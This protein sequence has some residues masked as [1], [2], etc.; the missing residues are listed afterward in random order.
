M[1]VGAAGVEPATC[2]VRAGCSAQLS[3][4]PFV[5]HGGADG[6]RTRTFSLDRRAALAL[7]YGANC[8]NPPRKKPRGKSGTSGGIR[9]L[10]LAVR[11]RVLWFL[12]SY[13]GIGLAGRIRTCGLV[14]PDHAR[15]PA[16]LQRDE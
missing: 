10:G 6:T 4:A 8:S 12:L 14:V 1:L 15:W 16:A 5:C 3:Y 7:S 9:T 13:G 2:R 11:S